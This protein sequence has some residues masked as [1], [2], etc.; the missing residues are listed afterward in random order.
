VKP[1]AD[2]CRGRWPAQKLP[3]IT[4]SGVFDD[5]AFLWPSP[6]SY[7]VIIPRSCRA[8]WVNWYPE[9]YEFEALVK[10]GETQRS[11]DGLSEVTVVMTPTGVVKII[12]AEWW[13]RV[14]YRVLAALA[15]PLTLVKGG[16]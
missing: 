9:R 5:A 11:D 12:P 2:E 1:D 16:K 13:R 10:P 3:D 8:F 15:W 6:S 4:L 14:G 7:V